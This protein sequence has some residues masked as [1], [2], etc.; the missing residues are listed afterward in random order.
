MS[1]ALRHCATSFAGCCLDRPPITPPPPSICRCLSSSLFVNR[2]ECSPPDW[3]PP[4]S[5]RLSHSAAPPGCGP[6]LADASCTSR[7]RRDSI[8]SSTSSRQHTQSLRDVLPQAAAVMD[9]FG[10]YRGLCPSTTSKMSALG[11]PHQ[12]P[13][14]QTQGSRRRRL[15]HR[16]SPSLTYIQPNPSTSARLALLTS[17]PVQHRVPTAHHAALHLRR[18]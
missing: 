8:R 13:H 12:T 15:S 5:R 14:S 3:L 9:R 18:P 7:P 10:V 1:P 17:T 2:Q 11:S 6:G 16:R 4:H